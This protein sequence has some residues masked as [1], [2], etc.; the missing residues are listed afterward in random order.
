VLGTSVANAGLDAGRIEEVLGGGRRVYNASLGGAGLGAM[1]TW[2]E[3]V[4]LPLACPEHVIIAISP[5]DLNDSN[6]EN[7]FPQ[8]YLASLGRAEL[9]DEASVGERIELA[10]LDWSGLVRLRVAFRNPTAAAAWIRDRS[11]PWRETN[12]SHGTLTRFQRSGYNTSAGRRINDR[13]VVFGDYQAGGLR[14]RELESLVERITETG[15]SVTIATLPYTRAE[16]IDML[17]DGERDIA[18]YEAAVAGVAERT[19][20]QLIDLADLLTDR[21]DFADD[22]HLNGESATIVSEALARQL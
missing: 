4:V 5:R 18:E 6:A 21:A 20:A 3:D 14:S 10:A 19:G 1:E 8:Q 2:A 7:E 13:E 12:D 9:L 15:A 22:Y 16:T 17:P 11:G